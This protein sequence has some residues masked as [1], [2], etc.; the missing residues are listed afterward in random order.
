MTKA[1]IF[2]FDGLLL[3]TESLWFDCYKEVLAEY[4][5]DLPLSV[6]SQIIGTHNGLFTEYMM[7]QLNDEKL[8]KAVDEKAGK[9]HKEKVATIEL[10]EGVREFFAEAKE[11][12]LK[13]GLATSSSRSWVIPFLTKFSLVDYFDV[14]K[15]SDDVKKIKPDPELYLEALKGLDVQ[16]HEAIVF[17]DSLNGATAANRAG[18]PCVIVPNPVTKDLDFKEYAMKLDSMGGHSLQEIIKEI[19]ALGTIKS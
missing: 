1:I 16:P 9:L 5:V 4:K 3:D 14:I 19:A 6:F 17:E 12:G 15:T 2:D 10:R 18:I 8:I 7:E 11:I 13:I